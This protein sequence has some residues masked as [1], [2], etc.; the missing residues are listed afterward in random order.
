MKFQKVAL[1]ISQQVAQLESRGMFFEDKAKA[2]HYLT[3]ISYYRL[4][5]YWYT[6]LE[7]PKSNHLFNQGTS[8]QQVIDTYVFDRKLRLLIFDEIERLEISLR[9]NL[10]YHFCHEFGSNWYEDKNLFRKYE[11]YQ[12]F[13][14]L[15]DEEKLRTSE[16]FIRH[17]KSKYHDPINPPAWMVLELA[18]FGQL[19]TLYKNLGSC[20]AKKK[21]AEHFKLDDIVLSSWLETLSYVRNT[22]AHHSRLWNR[23]IPKPPILPTNAGD[24]WLTEIPDETKKNRLYLVLSLIAYLLKTIVPDSRFC[25]K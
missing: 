18:S 19:S 21:V 20:D 6:F 15:M 17:Y 3:N 11:F 5:A 4:S 9:T 10:I 16:V 1:T 22:C 23:K 14:K 12:K 2:S 7:N 13:N 8:F 24:E 25:L